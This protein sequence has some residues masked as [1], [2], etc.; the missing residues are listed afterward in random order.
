M[1]ILLESGM[2]ESDPDLSLAQRLAEGNCDALGQI[3]SLYGQRMYAYA[4]RL[5]GDPASAEDVLQDSLTAAWQSA[6]RYRG[7]GRLISWLLGIVHRQALNRLRRR[8]P[9]SLEALPQE[10]P[11]PSPS[12]DEQAARQEQR[13]LLRVG[14]EAL[15]LE[16]RMVL[17]L[18]FYQGLSLNET[19]E[20]CGCPVGTV[21]SR[22]SYAK[23]GLRAALG[24]Q[25]FQAED[26]V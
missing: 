23:A 15:S 6:G 4:L 10:P 22:L 3:A 5:I 21:K 8:T 25:G 20:V 26:I 12:L 24:R 18:V 14:L 2:N 7:Q 17:E 19:A 11:A 13:D 16:H 9:A 1:E